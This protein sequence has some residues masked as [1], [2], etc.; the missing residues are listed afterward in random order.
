[1]FLRRIRAEM[2][3]H[4]RFSGIILVQLLLVLIRPRLFKMDSS[5]CGPGIGPF[6]LP[7]VLYRSA[8]PRHAESSRVEPSPARSRSLT[9]DRLRTAAGCANDHSSNQV[10]AARYT[11]SSLAQFNWKS[12]IFHLP[13][14]LFGRLS[15]YSDCFIL[16]H[17]C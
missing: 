5:C 8:T 14:F 6:P 1:M 12:C 7:R 13:R 2:A 16:L 17:Y 4:E 11:S 15:D 3:A 9:A 10:D